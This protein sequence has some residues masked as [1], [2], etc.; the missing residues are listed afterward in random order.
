M[1]PFGE[2][3]KY[4]KNGA[5]RYGSGIGLETAKKML[6]AGEKEAL[7][8]GVPVALAVC[9]LGGN[10]VAF[11]RMDQ[12]FLAGNQIAMDKAYTA[13]FG[14]QPTVNNSYPYQNGTLVPLFFHDR[15][16]TFPG[17]YPL[18]K[19]GTIAGGLGISGGIIEDVYIAR[20]V[21][22]AGGFD[23]ADVDQFIKECRSE[24]GKS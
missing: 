22:L 10:L 13:V 20:V 4:W 5:Y 23:T 21:I 16:I 8:Q 11:H 14:K 1:T 3:P 17:G 24:A 12:T 15:W 18:V 19:D 9:D 6:R 7:K 2:A